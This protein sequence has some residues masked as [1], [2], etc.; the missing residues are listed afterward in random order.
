MEGVGRASV[1]DAGRQV[2]S[3]FCVIFVSLI[4]NTILSSACEEIGFAFQ[5]PDDRLSSDD[6]SELRP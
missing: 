6:F 5:R 1:I 2:I 4:E 3:S